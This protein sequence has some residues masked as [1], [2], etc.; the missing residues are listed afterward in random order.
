MAQ[1]FTWRSVDIVSDEMEIFLSNVVLMNTWWIDYFDYKWKHIF[2]EE[3][4]LHEFNLMP[5]NNGAQKQ[6]YTKKWWGMK[7]ILFQKIKMHENA[8]Q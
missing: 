4:V 7:K 5:R 8:K 6:L 2:C 1:A 3:I